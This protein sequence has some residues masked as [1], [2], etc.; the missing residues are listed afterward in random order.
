[1]QYAH[2]HCA[3][4]LTCRNMIGVL[5]A[6]QL[7]FSGWR[8]RCA[9]VPS[10]A[11]LSKTMP[12]Y[13]YRGVVE[14]KE[15]RARETM[16]IMG[17]QPWALNAAWA[18]TYAVILA[19]V[20][21]TVRNNPEREPITYCSMFGTAAHEKRLTCTS[22]PS[23]TTQTCLYFHPGTR[24]HTWRTLCLCRWPSSASFPSY[25]APMRGEPRGLISWFHSFLRAPATLSAGTR[26]S[27]WPRIQ[28]GLHLLMTNN[29]RGGAQH[30]SGI[31]R[32]SLL[33]TALLLFSAAELAFGLMVAAA[34]SRAKIA[35]IMAPILHLASLM[36]RYIF[37]R[38]GPHMLTSARQQNALDS[39]VAATVMRHCSDSATCLWTHV[40]AMCAAQASRRRLAASTPC[41]CWRRR[42]SP[43]SQTSWRRYAPPCR[44]AACLG[45]ACLGARTL[46]GGR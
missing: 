40:P 1:M 24:I 9:Y 13:A 45:D 38:T 22:R 34:C 3:R 28:G 14:E 46:W 12:S 29:R 30:Q 41:R 39:V 7:C 25:R 10:L 11:T 2:P 15:T 37:F 31:P 6:V 18:A 16:C 36:P 32:C 27:V 43:S 17:L 19:I 8:L 5:L 35:A 33:V 23:C 26:P 42:R 4:H 21:L 20:S 44:A